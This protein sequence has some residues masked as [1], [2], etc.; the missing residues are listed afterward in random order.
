MFFGCY[1]TD[2]QDVVV[3]VMSLERLSLLPEVTLRF[4]AVC[5]RWVVK[6]LMIIDISSRVEFFVDIY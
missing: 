2:V 4:S 5:A 3:D 6:V 1:E